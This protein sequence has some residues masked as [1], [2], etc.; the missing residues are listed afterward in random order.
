MIAPH[1]RLAC[2]A[3]DGMVFTGLLVRVPLLDLPHLRSERFVVIC[4]DCGSRYVRPN[5]RK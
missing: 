5:G 4:R 2:R 1:A 3:C